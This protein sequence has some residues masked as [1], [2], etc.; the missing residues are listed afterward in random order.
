MNKFLKT[1]GLILL[2]LSALT[3]LA[4]VIWLRPQTRNPLTVSYPT[5]KGSVL[6]QSFRIRS[7]GKY[8]LYIT[9]L[10]TGPI[11][12]A[13]SEFG[14]VNK[15]QRI[16]CEIALKV[17]KGGRIVFED[18]AAFLNA[19]TMDNERMGY[20]LAASLECLSKNSLSAV[21]THS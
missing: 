11:E 4:L 5:T 7:P 19:A 15:P 13:A 6:H 20:R 2:L 8:G 9:C 10:R 16:A 14:N 12:Q 18:T 21:L 17:F 1:T 3:W